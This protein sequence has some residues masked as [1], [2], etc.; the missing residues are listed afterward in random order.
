MSCMLKRKA[1]GA[2]APFQAEELW[3]ASVLSCPCFPWTGDL[4]K[5]SGPVH[6]QLGL[7]DRAGLERAER[8]GPRPEAI[9]QGQLH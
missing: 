4:G 2:N 7:M 3:R 6:V 8:E 9:S 5:T 1:P